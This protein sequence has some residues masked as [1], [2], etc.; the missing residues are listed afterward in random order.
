MT[1]AV[2]THPD[3]DGREAARFMLSR[4]SDGRDGVE[5]LSGQ[6]FRLIQQLA[7]RDRQLKRA[8]RGEERVDP[9]PWAVHRC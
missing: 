5:Q 1:A 7:I 6:L 9:A 3:P 8:Q 2:A 4:I